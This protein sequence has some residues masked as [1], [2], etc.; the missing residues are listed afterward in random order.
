MLHSELA[1]VQLWTNQSKGWESYLSYSLTG[2][3]LKLGAP[4]IDLSWSAP[5]Q[6]CSVMKPVWETHW[7]AAIHLLFPPF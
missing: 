4:H 5:P 6:C 2:F 3:H 7:Y 1:A